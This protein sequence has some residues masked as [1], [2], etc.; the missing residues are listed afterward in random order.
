MIRSC[1]ERGI[2]ITTVIGGGYSK[3]HDEVAK[4]HAIV[5]EVAKS[6]WDEE[7]ATLKASRAHMYSGI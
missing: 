7:E 1:R 4:R 6:V 5:F 3:E 2:S